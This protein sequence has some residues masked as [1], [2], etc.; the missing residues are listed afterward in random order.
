L[1]F[2]KN[3]KKNVQ[4]IADALCIADGANAEVYRQNAAAY[5]ENWIPWT[6]PFKTWSIR[7]RVKPLCSAIAFPSAISPTLRP[8]LLCRLPRLRDRNRTEPGTVK[9]LIDKIREE[10]IPVVFHLELSN[11]K[12]AETISEATG[13]KVLLL[14]ACHNISNPI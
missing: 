9:F 11:R 14:H 13:A 10:K 5:L 4:K 8:Y 3:T 7:E 12:M 1:D 6:P 2:A